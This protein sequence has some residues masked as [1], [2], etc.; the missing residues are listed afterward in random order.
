MS[1]EAVG[2]YLDNLLVELEV[3]KKMRI[4]HK[5]IRTINHYNGVYN[6]EEY[7]RKL[8]GMNWVYNTQR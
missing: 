2:K 6:L 7:S 8:I 5:I 1:K 3:N 4:E